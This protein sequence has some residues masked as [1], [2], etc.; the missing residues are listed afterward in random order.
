ML[1]QI[2]VLH[3]SVVNCYKKEKLNFSSFFLISFFVDVIFLK[4]NLLFTLSV[5]VCS[6]YSLVEP[7]LSAF[8]AWQNLRNSNEPLLCD[9]HVN[10]M[11]I[12]GIAFVLIR[13]ILRFRM[14]LDTAAHLWKMRGEDRS[15][16]ESKLAKTSGSWKLGTRVGINDKT[17]TLTSPCSTSEDFSITPRF[18]FVEDKPVKYIFFTNTSCEFFH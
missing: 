16:Q 5:H 1:L 6:Q 7:H 11:I 18:A 2:S 17:A 12:C 9:H 4:T 14:Y 13:R 15:R 8:F 3:I 10:C